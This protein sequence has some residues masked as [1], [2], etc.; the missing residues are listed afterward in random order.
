MEKKEETENIQL[1]EG[2]HKVVSDLG[3]ANK[4]GL[5]GEGGK[6]VLNFEIT[7]ISPKMEIPVGINEEMRDGI[8][9]FFF[10]WKG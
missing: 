8:G 6:R 10:L 7:K 9:F 1:E 4:V 2:D 5:K 3:G